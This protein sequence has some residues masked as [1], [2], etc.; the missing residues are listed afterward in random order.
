MN[1]FI[2]VLGQGAE[3]PCHRCNYRKLPPGVLE[4]RCV[5][6]LGTWCET[7]S[8]RSGDRHTAVRQMQVPDSVYQRLGMKADPNPACSSLYYWRHQ[9][10]NIRNAIPTTADGVRV[11][12]HLFDPHTSVAIGPDHVIGNHLDDILKAVV[13]SLPTATA[14]R[15]F[16]SVVNTYAKEKSLSTGNRMFPGESHAF[17]QMQLTQ[18]Y[19]VLPF[20]AQSYDVAI[21]ALDAEPEIYTNF[22]RRLS[23]LLH[24]FTTFVGQLWRNADSQPTRSDDYVASVRIAFTRYWS[25]LSDILEVPQAMHDI[26]TNEDGVVNVFDGEAGGWR[27]VYNTIRIL[28]KPNLHR[29]LE[30]AI[31]QVLFYSHTCWMG[32]LSLERTHQRLKAVMRKSNKKQEQLLMMNAARFNDWQGRLTCLYNYFGPTPNI[33]YRESASLISGV[34]EDGTPRAAYG[35]G[36]AAAL[37]LL[38]HPAGVVAGELRLQEQRVFGNHGRY[39]IGPDV[40]SYELSYD[41][42]YLP[43]NAFYD[44]P[45][46]AP[47]ILHAVGREY[48]PG[49]P[50]IYALRLLRSCR[51]PLRRIVICTGDIVRSCITPP[52]PEGASEYVYAQILFFMRSPNGNDVL[53][54][55]ARSGNVSAP[56]A[57]LCRFFT[58]EVPP[59]YTV[60]TITPTSFFL[61]T[62][63]ACSTMD[64][65]ATDLGN[66]I[67]DAPEGEGVGDRFLIL[68][69]ARAFP[70]RKG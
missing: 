3:A 62:V 32:E 34:R 2:D 16:I 46:L 68:D 61:T 29:F 63:H 14:R 17:D 45:E 22:R 36:S 25:A 5:G 58:Q 35:P 57:N 11:V 54:Y 9:L 70:P 8:R 12:S 41:R 66:I 20:I 44:I 28:D 53:E 26:Y 59:Q 6:Q 40:Y 15:P 67:H 56:D 49:N 47:P 50:Q 19:T 52:V 27:V 51:C 4:S 37:N 10:Y 64:C 65:I 33:S 13:A 42:R 55:I 38:L 31:E 1:A 43:P 23:I 24:T 18:K 60:G 69:S 30:H 48:I 7:A 21:N 39:C